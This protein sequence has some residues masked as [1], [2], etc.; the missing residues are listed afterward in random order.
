L[1]VKQYGLLLLLQYTLL[2]LLWHGQV[3]ATRY[4]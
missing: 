4:L 1:T 3:N 2:L